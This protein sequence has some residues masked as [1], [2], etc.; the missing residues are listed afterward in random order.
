MGIFTSLKRFAKFVLVITIAH[1]LHTTLMA[2]VESERRHVFLLRSFAPTIVRREWAVFAVVSALG[3]GGPAATGRAGSSGATTS[4]S[5]GDTAG[6]GRGISSTGAVAA[7]GA[8]GAQSGSEMV[9]GAMSTQSGG[10]MA[11]S[12]QSASGS[13]LGATGS[14]GSVV[15]SG[16]GLGQDGGSH[17]DTGVS[18][19]GG[20]DAGGS[21]AAKQSLIWVWENYPSALQ[22]VVSH[23]KS[24]THVSPALYQLNYDYA[25]GVAQLVNGNDDFGGGLT[26]KSIAQ[27][28]RA[29]G[30][31][32][33][34]LMYAGAGNSGT[35]QGIQNVLN[36]SPAGAQQSFIHSMV[37]EAMTKGYD[38]YNLDWEVGNTGAD[39]GEKLVSFLSAFKS[40]LNAEGM[41]LTLDV[42]GWYISQCSASG[43][44]ALV[45]LTKIGS[46]LDLAII[47]D[48]AGGLGGPEQTCAAAT[49][50]N[51]RDCGDTTFV[52]GLNV[53]CNLPSNAV[54]IGLIYSANNGGADTY[55]AA[56]LSAVSSYG[57]KAVAVWP[58]DFG[59]YSQ[60]SWYSALATYLGN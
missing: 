52:S 48:Y 18:A 34:P 41:L 23:A 27:M 33:M 53:M 17:A 7:S 57:Y 15:D 5:S 13:E 60:T 45:D 56:A 36:D 11:G 3:C 28:I 43:G 55:T 59:F 46:S 9:S 31:K 6:S 12:G 58:D 44:S 10:E 22:S 47:E 1:P 54:S 26:S 29:A 24:F 39:Y 50:N 14:A 42:A 16:A 38:G 37:T 32:C 35:D 49:S 21:A 2:F 51:S 8:I 40:A 30:L 25:S 19:S 4:R 20:T